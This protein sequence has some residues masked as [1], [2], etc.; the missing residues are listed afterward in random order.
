MTKTVIPSDRQ[1][2]HLVRW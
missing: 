2:L 1:A